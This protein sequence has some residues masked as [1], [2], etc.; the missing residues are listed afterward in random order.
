MSHTPL[1]L[2]YSR[3]KLS[4][5][6]ADYALVLHCG[7]LFYEHPDG[8]AGTPASAPADASSSNLEG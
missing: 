7:V 8:A 5:G 3:I 4:A 1:Q 2:N 6:K